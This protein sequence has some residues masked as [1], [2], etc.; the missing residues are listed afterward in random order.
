M[1]GGSQYG[2]LRHGSPAAQ[3]KEDEDTRSGE[4]RGGQ[5]AKSRQAAASGQV[6]LERARDTLPG[7]AMRAL[8]KS[9]V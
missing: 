3:A 5:P 1:R 4:S 7:D 8:H 6:P 9:V 2:E